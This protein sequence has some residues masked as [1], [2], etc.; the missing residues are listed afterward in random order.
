MRGGTEMD[1]EGERGM[2]GGSEES[3]GGQRIRGDK[4][5]QGGKR[6]RLLA[7]LS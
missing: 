1:V 3:R 4:I 6:T 2:K 7:H 5:T